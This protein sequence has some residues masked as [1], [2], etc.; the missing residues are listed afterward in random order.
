MKAIYLDK[1]IYHTED[2]HSASGSVTV[3]P[4]KAN[5]DDVHLEVHVDG[6]VVVTL[7]LKSGYRED[8]EALRDLIH[9]ADNE[10]EALRK[11]QEN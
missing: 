9:T 5:Y 4:S 6:R 11:E 1:R 3:R 8:S 10:Q 2:Q 7:I